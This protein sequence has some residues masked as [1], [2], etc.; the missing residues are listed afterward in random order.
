M[1]ADGGRVRPDLPAQAAQVAGER[2]GQRLGAAARTRPAHRVAEDV[3][4]DGG[5]PAAGAA[6][7]SVAMHRGAVEPGAGAGG[8]EQPA[9]EQA[10][11]LD[12]QPGQG[13]QRRR[14][15][16]EQLQRAA[17]RR[18]A[19]EHRVAHG[20]EV[21]DQRRDE[22][23]PAL[24]V[25]RRQRVQARGGRRHVA[26]EHGGLAVRE[27]MR[28]RGGRLHP[29]QPEA[30]E[31][32]AGEH[33]RG[34]GGRVDGREDVVAEPGQGQRLGADRAAGPVGR[35]EHGDGPAGLGEADGGG[36]PVRPA[37]DDDRAAHEPPMRLASWCGMLSRS[38]PPARRARGDCARRRSSSGGTPIGVSPAGGGLNGRPPAASHVHGVVV[39]SVNVSVLL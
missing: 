12:E 34:G 20:A 32:H 4:V 35:L 14:A 13:E 25:A 16:P 21:L 24:A 30:L 26:I 7:R 23:R 15:L 17:D 8:M 3:E 28:H 10:R 38:T 2:R 18:E 33:R 37:A 22:P 27:R 36:E 19:G 39:D 11:R 29:L 5:D 31:R 1:H 6:W 9:A